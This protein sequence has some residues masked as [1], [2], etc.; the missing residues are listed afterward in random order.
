MGVL[1]VRV[2]LFAVDIRAPDF[3]DT[4][5]LATQLVSELVVTEP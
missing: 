5:W 4:L 1:V 3:S 2:L